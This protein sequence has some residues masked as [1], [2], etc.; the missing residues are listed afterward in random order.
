MTCPL[1]LLSVLIWLPILG[2]ALVLVCLGNAH[3]GAC[4]LDRASVAV[5]TFVLPA[6][7]C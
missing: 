3:P 1:A 7:R 5:L 6:C 2:G 4:A